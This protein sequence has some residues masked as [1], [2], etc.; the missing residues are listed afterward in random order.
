M[1]PL[2]ESVR[3]LVE[4]KRLSDER[5]AQLEAM[6]QV[7]PAQTSD[8]RCPRARL[9][10]V[11][12]LVLVLLVPLMIW[13]T[14]THHPPLDL[15]QRIADE[16]TASHL[17]RKPMEVRSDSIA[18][19]R[20]YLS[21]L[22]FLP[23]DSRLAQISALDMEGARYCSVQGAIA[24]Q[25][26]YDAGN[27]AATQTLFQANYDPGRFGPIPELGQ[28]EVPLERLARGLRVSLWVEKG[29]LNALIRE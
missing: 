2:S 16:V 7:P 13:L 26:R 19:V 20:V 15:S 1:R 28:G 5:W 14:W 18:G 23:I 6:Q 22:D 10:A 4:Q 11:A 29:I 27:G 25:L 12:A 24:A 8:G 9:A 17:K 21:E 3:E